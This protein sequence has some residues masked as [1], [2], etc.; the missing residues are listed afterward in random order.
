[1]VD[2]RL[3]KFEP[4]RSKGISYREAGSGQALVMLHGIGSSSAAWLN[5]LETLKG[6]R[7]I[8]WDAP[9]YGASEPVQNEKPHPRDYA[10]ALAA[11]L[12]RLLLKD[13]ILV[14][15]SLGCLMAAAYMKD[16]QDKVRKALLISPA[17]G[18]GG[19]TAIVASRLK[20]L[21]ELGP[22]GM[23]QQRS[24][25]LLAANHTPEAL[26]LV[27]WSQRR[28]H[29]A[30]YTQAVYSL[31][32]G[33]LVDDAR[34]FRKPVLVVCGTEDRITPE[35]GCKLVA[36]AFPNAEYRSLEGIGHAAQLEKPEFTN[37]LITNFAK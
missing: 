21:E 4:R 14:G 9:G 1:V 37:E 19:D 8:A 17:S 23:A 36:Q 6:F 30:G 22:E 13:V 27:R 31:A 2:D 25:T 12:D 11:F 16:H 20:Q 7:M 26:E 15:N 5:Q 18:Y 24:P 28:I 35:A 29:P 3:K 10:A 33:K 32:N 34:H